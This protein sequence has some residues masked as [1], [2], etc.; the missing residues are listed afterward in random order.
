[1]LQRLDFQK[2]GLLKFSRGHQIHKDV[3][4]QSCTSSENKMVTEMIVKVFTVGNALWHTL[5]LL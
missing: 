1:M 4:F 2:S 5:A 3:C